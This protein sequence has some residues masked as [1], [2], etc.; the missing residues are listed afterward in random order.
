MDDD[1]TILKIAKRAIDDGRKEDARSLLIPVMKRDVP[2]AFV[3]ASNIAKNQEHALKLLQ[4]A[5]ALDPDNVRI[6]EHLISLA[7]IYKKQNTK[8]V[9]ELVGDSP[10]VS[11]DLIDE[12]AMLFKKYGWQIV[13]QRK[14]Y[15]QFIRKSRLTI[16]SA[17]LLAL[18]F[19]FFGVLL[20]VAIHTFSEKDHVFIEADGDIL[21]VSSPER[22]SQIA[23]PEQSLLF[24][25]KTRS[26]TISKALFVSIP[27]V[28]I[29]S[30][31]V[32]LYTNVLSAYTF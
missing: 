27:G 28:I 1:K 12:T 25:E 22:D 17:F 23:Y 6:K 32:V 8:M 7:K 26:I 20:L 31:I 14:G 16:T 4:H 13:G 5:L 11:D 29:N 30:L 19:N 10:T 3:L 24:L 21:T 15:A 9:G 2:E 18:V